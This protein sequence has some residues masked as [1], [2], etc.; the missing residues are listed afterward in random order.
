MSHEC[1][2]IAF[3]DSCYAN[4]SD[5]H[6]PVDVTSSTVSW[7]SN[8]FLV[9]SCSDTTPF[10]PV[11]QVLSCPSSALLDDDTVEGLDCVVTCADG[12]TAAG[13]TETTLTCVLNPELQ[14]LLLE[15]SAHPC[16]LA[17]FH[18]ESRLPRTQS[19]RTLAPPLARTA[20]QRFQGPRFPLY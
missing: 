14:S 7:G 2:R 15:S 13:D 16:E 18:S 17:S 3:L 5:G 9:K 10:Y 1:D 4:C 20:M 11:C 12:Y 8:G 19:S 6:A